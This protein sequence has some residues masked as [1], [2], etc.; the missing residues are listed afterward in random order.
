MNLR[1]KLLSTFSGL[2]VLALLNAGLTGWAIVSWQASNRELNNHYQRS[3]LVKELKTRVINASHTIREAISTDNPTAHKQFKQDLAPVEQYFRD[4]SQLAHNEA[5][6]KQIQ[7]LNDA[8]LV[9]L[10]DSD[11]IWQLLAQGRTFEA[12]KLRREK[13][14]HSSFPQFEKLSDRAINSDL[15]YREKVLQQVTENQSTAEL[16]LILAAFGTISLTLLLTA[17]LNSDLFAP[18]K[19]IKQGLDSLSQGDRQINLD[20]ERSDEIGSINR[21]FNRLVES[22]Q[23]RGQFLESA[24]LTNDWETILDRQGEITHVPSRL[25]LHQLLKQMKTQLAQLDRQNLN[26]DLPH[27]SKREVFDQLNLLLHTVT[28]LAEFGF[29]LDLNLSPTDIRALLYE[30]LNSFQTEFIDRQINLEFSIAPEI[31]PVFVDRLKLKEALRQL[32]DN[33]LSALPETGGQISIFAHVKD[34]SSLI[35]AINDNGTGI[36][37]SLLNQLFNSTEQNIDDR[38]SSSPMGLKLTKAIV[39]QHGGKLVFEGNPGY[40]TQVQINLPIMNTV[41]S[42]PSSLLV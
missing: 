8:Y 25:L 1:Q 13:L 28:H 10:D 40:G 3:L 37:Q 14:N 34:S 35:I 12:L 17:Y 5:E 4:W 21:A 31:P 6:K 41:V 38:N 9:L 15:Q 42:A 11:K 29:P 26:G 23:K 24:A 16:V 7:Q 19:E 30:T 27:I 36:R 32:I 20:I 39:E 33:A 18:L 22:L 2:A